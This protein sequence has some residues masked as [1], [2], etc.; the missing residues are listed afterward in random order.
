MSDPKENMALLLQSETDFGLGLLR[1]QNISESLAFSPLSIALALSLVHVAAKGETRD[2]I[3][4]ALVKGSTDEQLE[5]HFAN[6]SAAL[7]AAERG[8]EVK[9]ANHV[10]TRA[11]FKIKQ[12]YLD[13]VKKLYNA[14]ASSLD[15]DNKEATAEAINNFVRENTGDH[16]KKIIGSD[17]INSDLVA[18]LTNALYF[19]ADWQNKFKKDSTFKSEFF[20]SADSKREIDFLHA[21]SV[22]R[23]YAENDQFQVLSLP[24]KDNTFALTIFL[25]KTRFGLTESLKTLDSATIQHLLSNVSSTSV[26]VQIPKWKIETKLGLEEAL[27]SLGIKKAFDNDADLGNMADGLYVSKV[28][29]KALIEVD[30]EGTKAAAATTVSISLKSAMFVMEE[31]KD[32][33]ADHPFFF[34][35]SKDNHPLFVGLHH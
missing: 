17:S 29:H 7:L 1:Q 12:S 26:N 3:R 33:T 4:E 35:L 30:E 24:Y 19:K 31:P 5:Q 10:F 16:I 11:G 22:S 21:S 14:G 23:D 13:D 2:Q 15:F 18:V 9:L 32:F 28:T 20:S 25:P 27:Q 8:T 6:I 34:V